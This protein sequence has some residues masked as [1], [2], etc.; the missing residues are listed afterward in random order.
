MTSSTRTVRFKTEED[1]KI[2]RFLAGN[3]LFDFSTLA[4]IAIMQFLENPSVKIH[5]P[6]NSSVISRRLR[7]REKREARI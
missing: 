4:R 2:E 1:Q 5:I 3:P 7:Q 6:E